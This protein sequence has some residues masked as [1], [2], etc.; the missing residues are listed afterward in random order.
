[1]REGLVL[2]EGVRAVSTALDAGPNVRFGL[3]S[4]RLDSSPMGAAL[5]VRLEAQG[6]PIHPV[7]EDELGALAT[8]ETSQGV[9]LVVVEPSYS[10]DDLRAP[11]RYLILDGVQDPGNAGT[12]L[13]A[14]AA[15]ALNGVVALDGTV[16]LWTPK[17]VRAAAGLGFSLPVAQADVGRAIEHFRA[18][19]VGLLVA[20]AGG[21]D[22]DTFK[23]RDS[24]ALVVGN[25]GSGVRQEIAEV[26][27]ATLSVPM[28]GPAESLNVG[29]AGS[30]L[31][32]SLFGNSTRG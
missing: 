32:Y 17:A 31:L 26:A 13:R 4:S 3:V 1:M 9:L 29:V 20:D 10:L 21:Q 16:D 24:F 25:E 27:R 30:I 8:T 28:P 11:G 19:G 12:L 15:F 14:A 5:R 18:L 22:V 2:V 6:F 23:D 7:G